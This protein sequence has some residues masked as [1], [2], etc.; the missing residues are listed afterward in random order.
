[1]R[2]RKKQKLKMGGEYDL[3]YGR[4][5]YCYLQRSGVAKF[6]KRTLSRRRRIES[7]KEVEEQ[8]S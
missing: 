6:I 8:L 4:R 5:F 7:K 2:G 3:L 1:M